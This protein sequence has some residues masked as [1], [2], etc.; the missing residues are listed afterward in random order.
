MLYGYWSLLTW[1]IQ[2]GFLSNSTR[3][4]VLTLNKIWVI[5]YKLAI[6]IVSWVNTLPYHTKTVLRL[7]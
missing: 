1:F 3:W 4:H 5:Y 7:S 6:A 2:I